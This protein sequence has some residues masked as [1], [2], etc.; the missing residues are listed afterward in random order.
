MY[1][2]SQ[3][4]VESQ[5]TIASDKVNKPDISGNDNGREYFCVS[6]SDCWISIVFALL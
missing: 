6:Y 2:I 4:D 5:Q 1:G 3:C